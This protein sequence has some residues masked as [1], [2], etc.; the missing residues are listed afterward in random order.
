MQLHTILDA[1]SD[2]I[3]SDYLIPMQKVMCPI[4]SEALDANV[5][6]VILGDTSGG[7]FY[8]KQILV[9]QYH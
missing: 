8:S 4:L 6:I 1:P 3:Q 7:C 2:L 5:H 9:V